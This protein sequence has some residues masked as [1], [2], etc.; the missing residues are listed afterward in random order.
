MPGRG[1]RLGSSISDTRL[2]HV[3]AMVLL[4]PAEMHP[5]YVLHMEARNHLGT[6]VKVH[7]SPQQRLLL[8]HCAIEAASVPQPS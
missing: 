6:E 7:P 2:T 1:A 5:C 3:P 4:H 8:A